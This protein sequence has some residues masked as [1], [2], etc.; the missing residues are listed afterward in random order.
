MLPFLLGGAAVYGAFVGGLYVLQDGLIF[1]RSAARVACYPLPPDTERLTLSS[2][3]GDRLVGNLVRARGRTRGLVI[4]FSGNAWNADDYTT[5]LARRLEEF[6]VAVFHY[7]GYVPSEG[8]PSEA[9]LFADA[10]LIHDTLV[11]GLRPRRVYAVG[12]SLG[13][14]VAA[15]LAAHRR[16]DGA[17]LI[18]PFDSVFAIARRRYPFVP[19]RWLLKHPFRSDLHLQGA[20][21]PVAIL[22]A[23]DDT[24]VPRAHTDALH[25]ILRRPVLY[26]IV[27][28]THSG[29]YD[30]PAIDEALRRAMD[31]LEGAHAVATPARAD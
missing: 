17:L 16:L 12:A 30:N 31:A 8:E 28:G 23:S 10:R 13:S 25:R 4:G 7:R 14:G 9:A 2:E 21:V 24:V 22:A 20:D 29:I 18:T 6:D 3:D 26:E 27:E 19:V 5:F 15:H 11:H 1:A